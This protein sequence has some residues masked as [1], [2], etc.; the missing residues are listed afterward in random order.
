MYPVEQEDV[1]LICTFGRN[2]GRICKVLHMWDNRPVMSNSFQ[3]LKGKE[4]FVVMSLGSPFVYESD[5]Q[6]IYYSLNKTHLLVVE[7]KH[8]KRVARSHE[9][10]WKE[11]N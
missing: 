7:S 11:W 8:L 10:K 9:I 5:P 4:C 1:A 2:H 6:D 3:H